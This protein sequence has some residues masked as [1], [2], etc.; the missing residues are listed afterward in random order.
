M[1]PYRKIFGP[2]K[3]NASRILRFIQESEAFTRPEV[4]RE[5]YF[6]PEPD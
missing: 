5:D 3:K 2:T 4:G 1:V 6:P